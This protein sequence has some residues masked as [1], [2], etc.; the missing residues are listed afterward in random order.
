MEVCSNIYITR[1]TR[2][3]SRVPKVTLG[4]RNSNMPIQIITTYAPNN[5]RTEE[6]RIQHWGEV[7]EILN[8]TCKRHMIIWRTDANGQI[9]WGEEG[10]AVKKCHIHIIGPYA[11]AKKT[12]K[13]HG[14]YLAKICQSHRMIPARRQHGKS[15]NGKNGQMG[16]YKHQENMTKERWGGNA[17]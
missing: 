11:R 10:G 16:R 14:T 8:M 5:G 4:G 3:R 2:K 12:G 17:S 9:G 1:I 7:K 15:Q 13:G 6:Y